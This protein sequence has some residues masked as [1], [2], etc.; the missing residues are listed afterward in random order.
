MA[1]VTGQ[2]LIDDALVLLGVQKTGT[3]V[4][5][6]DASFSFRML[7]L[8]IGSLSAYHALTPFSAIGATQG[9][10]GPQENM[11]FSAL[12]VELMPSY[13]VV[14]QLASDIRKIAGR[15]E[16]L[17]RKAVATAPKVSSDDL[18]GPPYERF[19]ILR[20]TTT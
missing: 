6:S 3:V 12:A 5:G 15:A 11:V 2:V 10:S 13:G 9:L 18:G 7:N 8:A 1:S 17:A 20:R 4:A 16:R 14:G 19:N